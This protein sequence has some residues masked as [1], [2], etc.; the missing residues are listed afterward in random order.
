MLLYADQKDSARLIDSPAKGIAINTPHIK[1]QT[2]PEW[3]KL[4]DPT[5]GGESISQ[6]CS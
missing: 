2:E 3:R 4:T 6:I 1:A 5:G